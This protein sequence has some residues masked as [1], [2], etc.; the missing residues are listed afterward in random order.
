M[1]AEGSG[2]GDTPPP[3]QRMSTD[4]PLPPPGGGER[5]PENYGQTGITNNLGGC[6]HSL[7]SRGQLHGGAMRLPMGAPVES[8][9][10]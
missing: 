2:L 7:T 9:R 6:Q 3:N 10:P 8:P 1:L 4:L 5:S